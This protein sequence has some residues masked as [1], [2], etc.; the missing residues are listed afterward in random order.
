MPTEAR[1]RWFAEILKAGL[2]ERVFGPVDV[3]AHVTP[4]ILA[5]HLPAEVMSNVLTSALE[6]GSMTPERVLEAASPEVLA[7][8]IPHEALWACVAEAAERAGLS[9]SDKSG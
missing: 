8:H 3:L 2:E 4:E 5:R 7:E 9:E 6:G 1:Q